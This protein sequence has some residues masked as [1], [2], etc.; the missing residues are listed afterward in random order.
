MINE[1]HKPFFISLPQCGELLVYIWLLKKQPAGRDALS[2]FF[3]AGYLTEVIM[4]RMSPVRQTFS[5]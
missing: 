3:P 1:Q 4:G 2:A 5:A